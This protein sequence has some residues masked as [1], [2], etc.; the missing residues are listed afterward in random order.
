MVHFR[1]IFGLKSR[2][3]RSIE[4]LLG[5]GVFGVKETKHVCRSVGANLN[6]LGR[7]ICVDDLL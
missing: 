2:R 1:F 6:L 7:V 5:V 4:R 3:K